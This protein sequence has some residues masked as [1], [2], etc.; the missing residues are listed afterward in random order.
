MADY[1][2]LL[3]YFDG[4]SPKRTAE[5]VAAI[6]VAVAERADLEAAFDLCS[7]RF[8]RLDIVFNNAA[9]QDTRNILD[10]TDEDFDKLVRVNLRSV[11]IGTREAARRT[12]EPP[13]P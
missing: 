5:R 8:G 12:I 3:V 6:G 11:F 13:L 2:A 4:L 9:I 10:A 7:D 1:V